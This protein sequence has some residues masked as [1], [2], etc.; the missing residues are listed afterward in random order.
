MTLAAMKRFGVLVL[1]LSGTSL[2]GLLAGAEAVSESGGLTLSVSGPTQLVGI[3]APRYMITATITNGTGTA[4]TGVTV[5]S[6]FPDSDAREDITGVTGCDSTGLNI[7]VCTVADIPAGQSA[8]VTF[9]Y[10]PTE[11]GIDRHH[12]VASSTSPALS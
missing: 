4:A 8:V 12:L 9:R 2:T 10:R 11:Y 1:V 5:S 7:D 3:P 6:T